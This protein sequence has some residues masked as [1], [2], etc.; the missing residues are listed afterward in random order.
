MPENA[1]NISTAYIA[2]GL[3]VLGLA[4]GWFRSA[5]KAGR[6]YQHIDDRLG[7]IEKALENINTEH[8][9]INGSQYGTLRKH[10][11]RIAALEAKVKS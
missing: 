2:S 9:S 11:E 6:N 1:A 3:T 7:H 10:G 5:F 8:K 4:F